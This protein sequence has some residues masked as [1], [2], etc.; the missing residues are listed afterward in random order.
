MGEKPRTSRASAAALFG[1]ALLVGWIC[2]QAE[3]GRNANPA[4]ATSAASVA[5]I[6]DPF[7]EQ[8][9]DLEVRIWLAGALA[10][11]D[12]PKLAEIARKLSAVPE[13]DDKAWHGLFSCW[14]ATDPAAAWAF[15]GG[16][17]SL[18]RIAIEEW[19]ALDP[20]AA[21]VAVEIPSLG[22][23]PLLIKG[24]ARKDAAIAFQLLEQALAAGVK[25]DL[26]SFSPLDEFGL[27]PRHFAA[28]A[29]TNPRSVVA[30]AE[31]FPE[32]DLLGA[33]FSGWHET[34]PDDAL[35]WL[36][37]RPDRDDIL[38]QLADSLRYS[39]PYQGA[40]VDLLVDG[41]PAGNRRLEA[42][43]EVLEYLAYEDPDLAAKEAARVFPDPE[44]R[45]EAIGKIASIVAETD[46]DKA[47]EILDQLD[48]SVQGIRRV[49]LPSVE[50]GVGADT[51]TVNTY[52]SYEW[53]LTSMRGLVSPAEI[54]SEL[55]GR[56][57]D[58]DKEAAVRVM[59]RLAADDLFQIGDRAFRTWLFSEPE[60][61][62]RWLAPKLGDEFELERAGDF[63]FRSAYYDWKEPAVLRDL[64]QEL[65][66]GAVRSVLA[67]QAAENLAESDPLEALRFARDSSTAPEVMEEVYDTWAENDPRAALAH[68]AADPDAP[69]SAWARIAEDALKETPEEFVRKVAEISNDSS[70]DSAAAKIVEFSI[71][72]D[73]P[74]PAA[75]WALA[76]RG[77]AERQAA[78]EEVLDRLGGDLRL[79]RDADTAE[80]L[81]DLISTSPHLPEPEKARWLERI[82][83]EFTPP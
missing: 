17:D 25:I 65:P 29:A 51:R 31:R 6:A 35:A 12:A 3:S 22:E 14:F 5:T 60:E 62:I 54:R 9:E 24:A 75:G 20:A 70:H 46:F 56:L 16:N 52:S 55:L 4:A 79:A 43:H 15:A 45:A 82:D 72:S 11:A 66:N 61:A 32:A 38:F 49:D 33:A 18:R 57:I 1:G 50:L 78:M 30:W 40:L 64:I 67:L 13:L 48:L 63:M 58:V 39:V 74:L 68:L 73:D 19:A 80:S 42:L 23:W 59:G 47:W 27:E 41:L 28:L 77:E 44:L 8:P 53:D 71:Q 2:R 37:S 34:N 26:Q 69:P 83:L 76:I 21:R 7:P 10:E 36:Q 81:R